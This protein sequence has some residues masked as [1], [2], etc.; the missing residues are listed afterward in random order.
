MSSARPA[1]SRRRKEST[2][3]LLFSA[4]LAVAVF[5]SPAEGSLPR[6]GLQD[7]NPAAL[8]GAEAVDSG[9]LLA[10]GLE[11][12][13][14]LI[15]VEELEGVLTRNPEPEAD[16]LNL[17]EGSRLDPPELVSRA[18]DGNFSLHLEP[19]DFGLNPLRGPPLEI[20]ELHQGWF[21]ADPKTRIGGFRLELEDL[22]EGE[23]SLSLGLRRGYEVEGWGIAEEERPDPWGLVTLSQDN[24]YRYL[25]EQP[26]PLPPE[27]V[28]TR[29]SR[30]LESGCEP[31]YRPSQDLPV[32]KYGAV[33]DNFAGLGLFAA[34]SLVGFSDAFDRSVYGPGAVIIPST[35]PAGSQIQQRTEAGLAAASL[36]AGVTAGLRSGLR[37]G[38]AGVREVEFA[39]G[40]RMPNGKIAG[41]G[42][43][44]MLSEKPA[45]SGPA[46]GVLEVSGRVKST[47]AFENYNP[48]KPIEYVYDPT[49]NTFLVGK[50]APHVSVTGSPHQR[51][52]RTL[53]LD[54][55]AVFGGHFRRGPKGEIITDEQSGH[56]GQD[57]RWERNPEVRQRMKEF[58]E[59]K[60]GLTVIHYPF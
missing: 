50:P 60:T 1:G 5:A 41:E 53:G 58:L 2:P 31:P 29:L 17:V 13:F 4:L 20:P 45:G 24:T 46:P 49:T 40:Q 21:V 27:T 33:G 30:C 35:I 59:S 37:T 12:P 36:A 23:C 38:R 48:A 28:E 14:S 57:K 43:G 19:V 6:A 3:L 44:A 7:A 51:L 22:I 54:E 42:P 26:A 56:F 9:Q 8:A 47:K 25:D 34:N 32:T 15:T 18:C 11:T 39:P 55:D 10:A 16:V 52:A